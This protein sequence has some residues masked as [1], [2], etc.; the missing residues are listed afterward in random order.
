[1][2]KYLVGIDSGT[3]ST[4]VILYDTH[5]KLVAKGAAKHPALINEHVGWAEHGEMDT[6]NALCQASQQALAKFPGDLKDI[7]GIGICSQRAVTYTLDKEGNQLQRPIS[8]MDQRMATELLAQLQNEPPAVKFRAISSKA[9]WTKFNRPQIYEKTAKWLTNSGYLTYRLTGKFAD[10]AANQLGGA[11]ID[12]ETWGPSKDQSLYDL[13]GIRPDQFAELYKPGEVMGHLTKQAAQ[14]TGLPQGIPVVACAGDKQTE[15][16]GAGCIHDGQSYI[17][18]GTLASLDVVGSQVVMSP[19]STYYT[20]LGCTPFQYNYEAA[21]NKGYWLISWFRD[22]LGMDLESAAKE[23][24]VSIEQ[25]LN[26][27][28]ATVPPGSEGLVVVPDWQV[29]A[30]RPNGKGVILGFDS[31]H[32]RKHIFRAL[33]EGISQ[34]LKLNADRMCQ[35]IGYEVTEILAGGGGSQS[36]ITMQCTADI[37]NVPVRR[38]ATFET[39]SLGAAIS[40]AKGAGIFETYDE[41]IANMVCV[42]ETFEPI[43]ENVQ[44]YKEIRERVHSKVYTTLKPIFDELCELGK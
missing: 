42:G 34:Q 37:F 12:N 13:I 41:A 30:Y 11:P 4:R 18:F 23:R 26:E 35:Q 22:N 38:M 14:E 29:P 8:W 33:L 39:C 28:A 2:T 36:A 44:T 32:K 31:R 15:L 27:E 20:L 40:A 10:T 1:M 24:G 5:G 17:T 6:W 21:I 3:Q 16:L 43:P 19:D 25:L 9:N 7:V